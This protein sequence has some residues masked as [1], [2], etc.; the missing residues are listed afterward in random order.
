MESGAAWGGRWEG[1]IRTGAHTGTRSDQGE[2][3]VARPRLW[4]LLFQYIVHITLL[5]TMVKT[6]KTVCLDSCD[7]KCNQSQWM[8]ISMNIFELLTLGK[9]ILY[10][11]LLK[12]VCQFFSPQSPRFLQS[13][14]TVNL[15][16]FT[17][18][19]G[20]SN[21]RTSTNFYCLLTLSSIP[22]RLFPQ[23]TN[24]IFY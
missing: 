1:R 17:K 12:C 8:S 2:D 24:V 9:K 19:N 11:T 16:Y 20:N 3:L 18:H 15:F 4:A 23:H 6:E 21:L 7:I 22:P 5:L 10:S 13:Y 14:F